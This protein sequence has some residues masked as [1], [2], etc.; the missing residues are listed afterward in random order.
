MNTRF[1]SS[2]SVK[3]ALG[4]IVERKLAVDVIILDLRLRGVSDPLQLCRDMV[5]S[6]AGIPVMALDSDVDDGRE[7][8]LA[9]KAAGAADYLSR[10][11]FDELF[12]RLNKLIHHR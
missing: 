11:R 4:H 6:A 8:E 5:T 3:D 7:M 12:I 1:F 2:T 9:V 10:N